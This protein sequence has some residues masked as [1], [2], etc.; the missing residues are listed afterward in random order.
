MVRISATVRNGGADDCFLE[1]RN[2]DQVDVNAA[3]SR[4]ALRRAEVDFVIMID[5]NKSTSSPV[6]AKSAMTDD[7]VSATKGT[8]TRYVACY[9]WLFQLLVHARAAGTVR[10]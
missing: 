8:L 4:A 10:C 5:V 1:F 7:S 9:L 2:G 6:R 3:V